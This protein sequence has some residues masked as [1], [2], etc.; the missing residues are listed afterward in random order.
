MTAQLHLNPTPPFNF[1]ASLHKPD[2]FPSA[3]NCWQPGVRWQTMRWQ[4][5]VLGLKLENQGSVDEPEV[6]CSIYAHEPLE[7]NFL[8]ELQDEI[9]FRYNL[10]M[11]LTEFYTRFQAL[12]SLSHLIDRW[13]GMRPVNFSSLYEYLLISIMLQNAAVRRSVQMTQT[14]FEHFGTLVSFDDKALYCYW[15]P[16]RLREVSE[17]E[18]RGLKVGY[19]AK[20]IRR[21]TESFLHG[22]IDEYELRGKP[23]EEV[24]KSLLSLYGIGPASVGY[25]MSDVFHHHDE[26]EH[27]SP[28]EQKIY[29][30]LF[31]DRDPEDPAP[32][33][34]LLDYFNLHF[35][36]YRNLAVHYFWEDLWHRRMHEPVPWL[37]KLIRL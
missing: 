19:R 32:V 4:N 13:R 5:K 36:G 8:E 17:E 14:L 33:S 3:D 2:H 6:R 29:S 23:K 22:E 11:D 7:D 16:E 34:E 20:S 30:K 35:A 9:E 31:F 15:E 1:D 25:V 26:M 24:R 10:Q 28:W 21:V 12:P 37:E 27:I 18:L